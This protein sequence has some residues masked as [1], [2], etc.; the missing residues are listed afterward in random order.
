MKK[1]T[2]F[3]APFLLLLF[4]RKSLSPENANDRNR[5]PE[6]KK[7]KKEENNEDDDKKGDGGGGGEQDLVVDD[8]DN[9]AAALPPPN[10]NRSPRSV[11]YI[12]QV[13]RGCLKTDN[14]LTRHSHKIVC[15]VFRTELFFLWGIHKFRELKYNTIC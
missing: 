2:P 1:P 13:A 8:N 14:P 15:P 7:L 10:G 9:T 3:D 11:Y 4:Q 5:S 6:A 12:R